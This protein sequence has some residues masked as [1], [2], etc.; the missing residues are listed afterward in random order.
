MRESIVTV[1]ASRSLYKH[2]HSG[3]AARVRTAVSPLEAWTLDVVIVNGDYP[4]DD[5]RFQNVPRLASAAIIYGLCRY[6]PG[7]ASHRAK[8][9]I[10]AATVRTRRKDLAVE[11]IRVDVVGC[12]RSLEMKLYFFIYAITPRAVYRPLGILV[13]IICPVRY[14]GD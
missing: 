3:G 2:P 6:F 4:V 9:L 12:Y 5:G 1:R 11:F 14:H 13:V 10:Y 8:P 7:V